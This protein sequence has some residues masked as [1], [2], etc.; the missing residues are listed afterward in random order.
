MS[1]E[2]VGQNKPGK[3]VES[4]DEKRTKMVRHEGKL[5]YIEDIKNYNEV[6]KNQFKKEGEAR[7]RHIKVS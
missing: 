5:T 3:T 2:G 1:R 6:M 7:F 4:S